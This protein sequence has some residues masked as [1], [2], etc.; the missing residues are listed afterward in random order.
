MD[1]TID[2]P[3]LGTLVDGR[4]RIRARV[5]RGGMATVYTAVDE[6]LGR[7]VALKIIHPAQARDPRFVERFSGEAQTIARLTHPNVVAVYDQGTH[8]GLAYLVM[9]FVKGKTL[10][11]LLNER[12]RLDPQDA[13]AVMEQMLA[14]I[15]A[16]HRSGLVHRD[17]KPE[18]VLVSEAP[19]GSA[20]LVDSVV[21]VADFGLAQAVEASAAGDGQLM[22]TAAY[23]APELV[24]QGHADPRTDVYSAGI[25][26]FEML[27]G[28]VPYEAANV[29]E[30]AWKHVQEDVPPPSGFVSGL[31]PLID[32]LVAHA[33]SRNPA[34]R[35]TDAGA[36]YAEIQVVREELGPTL[37]RSQA[38]GQQTMM[39]PPIDAQ[40]QT[41][42]LPP[43]AGPGGPG[44]QHGAQRP[45]WARLPEPRHS[46]H[47]TPVAHRRSARTFES[48]ASR[49]AGGRRSAGVPGRTAA[50]TI[51][52]LLTKINKDP[53]VRIAT[54]S[55][56]AVAGLLLA[57]GIWWMGVGRYTTAPILTGLPKDQ[58]ITQCERAGFTIRFGTAEFDERA[59]KD[60]VL[61]QQPAAGAR[62]V[63]GGTIMVVL[64]KG[65][66]RY[67]LPDVS[68]KTFEA[69]QQELAQIKLTVTRTEVYDDNIP[70]GSVVATEPAAGSAIKPGE[71]VTVQVSK[72]RAPISVPSV[73]GLNVNQARQE[74]TKLGLTVQVQQQDG[75]QPKDQVIS[76]DPVEGAGVEQGANVTLFV[77]NGPPKITIPDVTG[78]SADD[79]TKQ[80]QA[81]GLQVQ[82]MGG[83]TVRMQD[84]GAGSQV[85][86]GSQVRL[87]AFG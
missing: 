50:E 7:T 3:L 44:S 51:G 70:A 18:N 43:V 48:S 8:Q 36:M 71:T 46:Q 62:T 77:S 66:E 65:A 22:A 42:M 85:E 11:D 29:V 23:V 35:P 82:V 32:H 52:P 10:R 74:L 38:A 47:S 87:V 14:A 27:T 21:K 31:P 1:T 4:Y 63:S 76:Q 79:A 16:A 55:V 28:R 30:V 6:R 41:T 20:S 15:A 13:L 59:A 49:G 80:L 9:E 25:V 60:T 78:L 64:S 75:T 53:K 56:I 37:A 72:G 26:L 67:E 5:A 12:Q 58:A 45:P 86:P 54:I 39:V 61:R 40:S 19:G 73:I 69:A 2:D 33:T 84:P 81:L 24:S 68:G 57:F 17:V 83:G 34:S